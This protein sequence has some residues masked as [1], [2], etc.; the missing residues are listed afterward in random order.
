MQQQTSGKLKQAQSAQRGP[1]RK[2]KRLRVFDVVLVLLVVA[3]VTVAAVSGYN[4]YVKASFAYAS[5]ANGSLNNNIPL[6]VIV[7]RSEKAVTA[8]APGTLRPVVADG[9]RVTAGTVIAYIDLGV[10]SFSVTAPQAGIVKFESDGFEEILSP[11]TLGSLDWGNMFENMAAGRESVF[12][13]S[14]SA[15]YSALVGLPVGKIIDNLVDCRLMVYME[16]GQDF[17]L[18]GNRITISLGGST[19][20]GTVEQ[21]GTLADGLY[22]LLN[23]GSRT[24]D[25][26]LKRY[27]EAEII[28]AQTSGMI[29]PASAIVTGAD[30]KE[31][32]FVLQ[33]NVLRYKEITVLGIRDGK[34][35]V[36]GI[37][38]GVE[39]VTNPRKAKDG[40]RVY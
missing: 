10:S 8:P 20:S 11:A 34:A 32:V 24:D 29:I 40:M 31:G 16:D 26:L 3:I 12:S 14:Y 36:S 6:Q 18:S 17:E 7:I 37:S 9:V 27:F 5:T 13:G 1:A 25:F 21:S 30:G 15:G 39:V 22:F 28:R 23:V 33:K 2:K 19:V 4:Y 38:A 35:A